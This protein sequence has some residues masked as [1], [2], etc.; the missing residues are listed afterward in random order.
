MPEPRCQPFDRSVLGGS[1]GLHRGAAPG[2]V[3][4]GCLNGS[5]RSTRSNRDQLG[6]GCKLQLHRGFR[7]KFGT[8]CKSGVVEA[9]MSGSHEEQ[10]SAGQ[11]NRGGSWRIMED[12]KA[13][14]QRCRDQQIHQLTCHWYLLIRFIRRQNLIIHDHQ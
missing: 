2:C 12:Q 7:D 3:C 10:S 8:S 11:G 4:R 14:R 5:N 13:K 6:K 9:P 1:L